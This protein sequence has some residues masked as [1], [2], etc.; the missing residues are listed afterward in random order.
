MDHNS[1]TIGKIVKNNQIKLRIK[2]S[3]NKIPFCVNEQ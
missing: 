1:R 2:A 3:D